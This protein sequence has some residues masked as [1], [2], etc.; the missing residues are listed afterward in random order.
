[1][2]EKLKKQYEF[3]SLRTKTE[4]IE[5]IEKKATAKKDYFDFNSNNDINYKNFKINNNRIEVKLSPNILD[6]FRG[7]GT[8]YFELCTLENGTKINVTIEPYSKYLIIAGGCFAILFL[9]LFTPAVFL[10]LNE[11][12]LETFLFIFG[13]CLIATLPS[14]L[15]FRFSNNQLEQ[16]SKRILDDLS[17]KT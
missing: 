2:L 7:S 6:P 13:T 16:Y 9:V 1:M 12:I 4:I 8:I 17:L 15:F 14:Y 5:E 10:F 11:N 3:Q